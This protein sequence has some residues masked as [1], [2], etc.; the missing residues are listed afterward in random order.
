MPR[1]FRGNGGQ[2]RHF[3][4]EAF[5]HVAQSDAGFR[6]QR[7]LLQPEATGPGRTR[8]Q[9]DNSSAAHV[10]KPCLACELV[11]QKAAQPSIQN[12]QR[13]R[14]IRERAKGDAL[15]S[16]PRACGTGVGTTAGHDETLLA[17]K[18]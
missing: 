9:K 16:G 1:H 10:R 4:G 11:G 6:H 13:A 14:V 18:S 2:G 17:L 12:V 15:R 7:C 3:H 8:R 5:D